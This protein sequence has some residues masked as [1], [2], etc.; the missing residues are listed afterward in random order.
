MLMRL[1]HGLSR[2]Q[3]STLEYK[4]NNCGKP[5]IFG[6]SAVYLSEFRVTVEIPNDSSVRSGRI[7]PDYGQ[8]PDT[9]FDASETKI[10]QSRRFPKTEH[11]V[12]IA[13][14]LPSCIPSFPHNF[15]HNHS[16]QPARV[17]RGEDRYEQR[18][19]QL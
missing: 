12:M 1:H 14:D 5:K 6:V 16:L 3:G 2:R 8:G 4:Q 11:A 19:Q 18:E 9:A 7:R 13:C 15:I 17:G 10:R